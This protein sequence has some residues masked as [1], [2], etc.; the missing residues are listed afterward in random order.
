VNRRHEA[1]SETLRRGEG[2]DGRTLATAERDLDVQDVLVDAVPAEG[3]VRREPDGRVARP[4]RVRVDTRLDGRPR[5]TA[6]GRGCHRGRGRG[7]G[8]RARAYCACNREGLAGRLLLLCEVLL[9]GLER[10]MLLLLL[11]PVALFVLQWDEKGG[12]AG[13]R[14]GREEVSVRSRP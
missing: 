2:S 8:L 5:R 7:R 4:A 13:G 11:G 12:G 3:A 1:V 6:V 14:D 9:S 10:L